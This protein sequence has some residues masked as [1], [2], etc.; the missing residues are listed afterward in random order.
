MLNLILT[1]LL[2][3]SPIWPLGQNPLVGDPY[4]IVNK[5]TNQL[6]YINHG[7]LKSIYDVATGYTDELTPEGEFT[8]VVKAVNP[9]YRK[10]NIEGGTK[11]N[12]LGTRW[13]GFDAEG[14]DGRIYGIH[15]NNNAMSI[16]HYVTQGCVRL[17]NNEIEQL[18]NEI[19]LGTKI[20]ITN[21]DM[22]FIELATIAGAIK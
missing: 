12:P 11:D 6:A 21:T 16:G 8:I 15:G 18:F 4:L 10:K 17:R 19:P 9:Y 22:S 3:V 2:T 20:K 5:Q 7:E 1:I 14:T 13:M